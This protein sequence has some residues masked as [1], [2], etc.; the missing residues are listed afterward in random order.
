MS[1]QAPDVLVRLGPAGVLGA[2]L[3]HPSIQR[4]FDQGDADGERYAV[5]EYLP[6][7]TLVERGELSDAAASELADALAYAHSVGVT[8]GALDAGAILFDAEGRPKL[9]GFRGAGEPADDVAALAALVDRYGGTP[10]LVVRPAHAPPPP[11]RRSRRVA[12]LLGALALGAA[13]VV[14]AV[15]ASSDDAPA[16]TTTGVTDRITTATTGSTGE[17]LPPPTTVGTTTASTEAPPT[18]TSDTEPPPSTVAPPIT[19]PPLPTLPPTEPPELP[20]EPP[21]TEEPPP[22]PSETTTSVPA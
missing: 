22:P 13:G 14:A 17:P 5:L 21:T 6:G 1:L 19:E 16:K 10:T 4:V 12:L 18:T 20:T 3:A 8:H 15:V 9:T 11:P 2:A 7:G